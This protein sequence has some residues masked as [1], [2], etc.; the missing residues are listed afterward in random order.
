MAGASA[1]PGASSTSGTLAALGSLF[2]EELAPR[3]GRLASALRT[4]LS[5]CVVLAVAM[6]LQI[7]APFLATFIAFVISRDDVVA[8]VVTGLVALGAITLAL[9]LALFLYT[10]DAGS[11]VVRLPML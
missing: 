10:F 11:A 2:R 8:S 5:C 6:V 7:P 4:A 9:A 3:P 1:V